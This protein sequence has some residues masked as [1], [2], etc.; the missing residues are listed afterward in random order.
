MKILQP[1]SPAWASP[2]V[3]LIV[4]LLMMSVLVMMVVGLAGVMRNEQAAA[5]NLTYQV[6]AEQ[7]AE[8]GARQGI[9][10]VLSA[11]STNIQIV[12]SGPGWIHRNSSRIPLFLT[13]TVSGVKNLE[14]FGTNSLILSL[15]DNVRGG[16][17]AGWSN[18]VAP[19]ESTARPMGR[20]S[21]WVDD[22]G[23]KL[24]LNLIGGPNTGFLALTTNFP[25][26]GSFVFIDPATGMTNN[27]SALREVGLARRPHVFFTVES[28]KDTNTT[29]LTSS[30]EAVSGNVYRRT[31]GHV[32]AWSSNL[33]LT[34][35][36]TRKF[37]LGD[38]TD[39]TKYPT[40]ADAQAALKAA[41]ATN[42]LT[43]FFGPNMTLA[44]K[45]GGGSLSSINSGNHGD[46][47]MDQI[48]ANILAAQGRP[49]VLTNPLRDYQRSNPATS[50]VRHRNSMPLRIASQYQGP[51]LEQVRARVDWQINANTNVAGRLLLWVRVINPTTNRYTNWSVKVQPRKWKYVVA[52]VA[53]SGFAGASAINLVYGPPLGGF[54]HTPDEGF[55]IVPGPAWEV[56][57]RIFNKSWPLDRFFTSNN[58][59]FNPRSTNDLF[60]ANLITFTLAGVQA[61]E[62]PATVSRAYV[63]L[64][65]VG[66]YDSGAPNTT[67]LRDW[68]THD[69]LAQL[70]NYRNDGFQD[71]GQFS[72][73]PGLYAGAG[74][75]PIN[76]GA[77]VF[78]SPNVSL[79]T[80]GTS[81]GVRKID[82]QARFPVCFFVT[83]VTQAADLGRLRAGGWEDSATGPRIWTTNTRVSYTNTDGSVTGITYLWPDPA[84]RVSDVLDH[85]HFTPGFY[86]TNGFTSIGQL[87]A[88]HTGIP[89]RTLR[90]QPQNATER[91]AANGATNSP[92]DWIVLDM[93]TATNATNFFPMINVNGLPVCLRGTRPGVAT[94]ANGGV[95]ARSWAVIAAMA[96]AGSRVSGSPQVLASNGVPLTLMSNGMAYPNLTLIASNLTAVLSNPASPIG[97]SSNSTWAGAVRSN[98]AIFP[99]NGLLLRG[100]LL[101]VRG[102]AEDIS[103]SPTL[104]EDVIEGRLRCFLDLMTT[105][106]DTFSVWSVGQGL[107]Y[108]TNQSTNAILMG[109]I[110]KQT[111]FQRIPMLDPNTGLVTNQQVRMLYTRN[112]V[113]E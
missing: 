97:W 102:V 50:F 23:S 19:G 32:T 44:R 78:P 48:T 47:V 63:M 88:I 64:D 21:Y 22:E 29:T 106:S 26:P 9:A 73:H 35:W 25:V 3:A 111:V 74:N 100:E 87:G 6:L 99:T 60:F 41:L 70:G 15:P 40:V 56:P 36:G 67:N 76:V 46:L 42:A 82:P 13:S 16:I 95:S 59:T 89:W 96:P 5:R 20:Y 80:P 65:Q 79:F 77:G 49:V 14:E 98:Q 92:P 54:P 103:A 2:G 1:K 109:E 84:P 91:S 24:N 8:I 69:D 90:L 39:T 86:V 55:N 31:K 7:L 83:N 93:L 101:E 105:R 37:P 113:I 57:S 38:L 10:E 81:L 17:Q 45:F 61:N 18:L 66:L 12:A 112:H 94:N 58:L 52:P 108:N 75:A 28:L 68:L 27:A 71:Y 62:L 34:P 33:D 43:N 51:Y 104:G 4:T 30:N 72:F 110:R 107:A 53:G 11:S 85:P